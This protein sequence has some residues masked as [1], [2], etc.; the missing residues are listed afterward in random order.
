[1]S[2]SI[3]VKN[4]NVESAIRRIKRYVQQEGLQKIVKEKQHTLKPSEKRNV[5]KAE[6]LK[7]MAKYRRNS[8]IS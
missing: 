3:Y 5:K 4:N 7:R 1:M 6:R 2:V 8:R